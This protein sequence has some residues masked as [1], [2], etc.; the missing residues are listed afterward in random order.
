MSDKNHK[1]RFAVVDAVVGMVCTRKQASQLITQL[2]IDYQALAVKE[3]TQVKAFILGCC[4]NDGSCSATNPRTS[5][6]RS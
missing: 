4:S 1:S 5:V 2:R 6:R 3:R